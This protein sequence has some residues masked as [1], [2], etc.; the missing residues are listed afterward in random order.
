[1][2]RY[3]KQNLITA[4]VLV[5]SFVF[6]GTA[7]AYTPPVI[8]DSGVYI[9]SNYQPAQNVQYQQPVARY[10]PPVIIYDQVIYRN[11]STSTTTNNSNS[12]SNSSNSNGGILQN[13]IDKTGVNVAS[14]QSRANP[15]QA[16]IC[17]SDSFDYTINYTNTTGKDA[18]DTIVVVTIPKEVDF[19]SSSANGTFN[20]AANTYTLFAGPMAKNQSGV[21]YVTVRANRAAA[22]TATIST[23]VDAQFTGD[24]SVVRTLTDYIVLS[25]KDCPSSLSAL[26]LGS[27][28]FPTSFFGWV[29]IIVILLL[30][31]YFARKFFGEN[32]HGG[33]GHG[34]EVEEKAWANTQHG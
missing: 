10:T 6:A 34:E 27:G 2:E 13:L 18:T 11:N 30:I 26:A 23:R 14:A 25:G 9:G 7:L 33:H 32:G 15:A 29:I 22:N 8:T 5:T 24:D 19:V 3:T 17:P 4:V 16:Q 21:L 1:M 12:T 28:F 20:A 31:I